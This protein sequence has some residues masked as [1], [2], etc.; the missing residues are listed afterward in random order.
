LSASIKDGRYRDQKF[1]LSRASLSGVVYLIEG[2]LQKSKQFNDKAAWSLLPPETL[3][4]AIMSTAFGSSNFMVERSADAAH[5]AKWLALYTQQ[6]Q[7]Q[8]FGLNFF[9]FSLC[10][11][12]LFQAWSS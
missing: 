8:V 12:K 1:R 5:T 3:E 2:P 9:F 10:L 11:K 7:D 6:L 4:A